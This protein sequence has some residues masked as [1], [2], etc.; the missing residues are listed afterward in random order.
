MTNTNKSSKNVVA[1]DL[2]S[3][4]V[5]IKDK[6]YP[7]GSKV[8]S[9]QEVRDKPDATNKRPGG[10]PERGAT[11]FKV[12]TENKFVGHPYFKED[13]RTS[14]KTT[15]YNAKM[16]L[17][18]MRSGSLEA[19]AQEYDLSL[20]A[21]KVNVQNT[22]TY[23]SRRNNFLGTEAMYKDFMSYRDLWGRVLQE[24]VAFEN[25]TEAGTEENLIVSYFLSV[26]RQ[27]QEKIITHLQYL[28]HEKPAMAS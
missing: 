25:L 17:M 24:H 8:K 1:M 12:S 4:Y 15:P 11:M 6:G 5:T 18:V 7:V 22:L 2:F 19:V 20:E 9:H 10:Q 16:A 27:A 26:N 21:L 3:E 28:L 13:E 23:I 14:K